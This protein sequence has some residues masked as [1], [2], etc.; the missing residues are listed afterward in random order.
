MLWIA[1]E[2]EYSNYLVLGLNYESNLSLLDC[3][4]P[5]LLNPNDYFTLD[6][7]TR[8]ILKPITKHLC[9]LSACESS[10]HILSWVYAKVV[11][12]S[13]SY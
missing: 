1:H 8:S 10:V 9:H 13:Y 11:C 7:H 6:W 3:N 12:P 5:H 2:S 4:H